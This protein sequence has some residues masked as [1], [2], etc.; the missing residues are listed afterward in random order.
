MAAAGGAGDHCTGRAGRA[1]GAQ[2]IAARGLP[3]SGI[4]RHHPGRGGPVH[5]VG[6][7]GG[8]VLHRAQ[9]PRDRRLV[10][11]GRIGSRPTRR[12]TR[13][14]GRHIGGWAACPAWPDDLTGR[15]VRRGSAAP[16]RIF[17]QIDDPAKLGA[18]TGPHGGLG[19]GADHWVFDTD[20]PGARGQHLV[21]E[22]AAGCAPRYRRRQQLAFAVSHTRFD[23][24]EP[25]AG[26]RCITAQA[27]HRCHRQT[28]SGPRGLR[29]RRARTADT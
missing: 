9:H 29:P 26:C 4:G 13:P 16:A 27:V 19:G 24:A 7:V 5:A 11:A 1:G 3:H 14:F 20:R 28:T 2:P 21:L 10:S 8:A 6:P 25:C 23:G 22:R 15:C 18:D 17:G 12:R